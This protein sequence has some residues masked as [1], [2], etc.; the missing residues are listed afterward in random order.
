M[1]PTFFDPQPLNHL[2]LT[3]EAC[4]ANTAGHWISYIKK[5]TQWY[6]TSDLDVRKV[7]ESA[8]QGLAHPVVLFFYKQK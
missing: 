8:L 1:H 2:D 4:V 5:G 6:Y 7:N 3:L